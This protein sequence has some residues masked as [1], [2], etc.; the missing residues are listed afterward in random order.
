MLLPSYYTYFNVH[1]WKPDMCSIV[2]IYIKY[3]ICDCIFLVVL[4]VYKYMY[5]CIVSNYHCI[6]LYIG[7]QLWYVYIYIWIYYGMLWMMVYT[8]LQY[9][10][11]C[12]NWYTFGFWICVH[13]L[14]NHSQATYVMFTA[15]AVPGVLPADVH[16]SPAGCV[17]HSATEP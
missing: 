16:L 2:C 8:I 15:G 13:A 17:E 12:K 4:C 14:Y 3:Y 9:I 1:Y 6:L 5:I 10:R 7:I 11:I